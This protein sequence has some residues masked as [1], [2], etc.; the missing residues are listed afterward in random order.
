M[1]PKMTQTN[2]G[3]RD[4]LC[5]L[6]AEFSGALG[7]LGTFLPYVIAITGAGI[8]APTP[9]FAAFAAGY[10]LVALVYR[11]PVAVQP[12]KAVGAL[13]IAG[14]L[15]APEV[16]WTGAIIGGFLLAFAAS[17][18]LGAAARAIPQSVVTGLQAG[19]GLVLGAVAVEL[20]GGQWGIALPAL[21][22]L[23][24]SLIWGRGPWALI[25]VGGAVVLAPGGDPVAVVSTV[26][27]P[28][29]GASVRAVAAGIV[30]QLPLTLL[31][32]VVVAAAVARSLFPARAARV[33]ERK[34]AATSGLLNLVFVPF[35]AL[36]MC[37]GAGGIAAHHRFGARGV[38]APLVMAVLCGAGALAGPQVIGWLA[39]IPMPVVGA[40]LLYAAA[41]LI[42]SRRMFDARADCRPVIGVAAGVTFAFGAGAGLIAGLM[43]EAVRVQIRRRQRRGA[44]DTLG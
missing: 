17:A 37:H 30:A 35:G 10:V 36:P 25:V 28:E 3:I 1:D 18:R 12:M 13:I 11:C 40:L 33:S 22:V 44:A 14:S 23:G 20:M 41:D 29:V 8:L 38:G 39:M 9:V 27:A 16:A 26:V 5:T 7:D 15:S 34:L 4:R 24:L 31:N 43:A 19:L 21:A 2:P 42:L 32:A 6:S